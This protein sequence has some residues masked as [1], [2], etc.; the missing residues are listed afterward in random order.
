MSD[1]TKTKSVYVAGIEAKVI[2]PALADVV[3]LDIGS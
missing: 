3:V 2:G 1:A